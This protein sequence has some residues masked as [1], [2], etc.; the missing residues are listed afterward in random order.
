[1]YKSQY[2]HYFLKLFL[3]YNLIAYQSQT[4][5]LSFN[6][7]LRKG[8]LNGRSMGIRANIV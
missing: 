2:K 7:H 5:A 4:I 1:M 6:T 8:D 3:I